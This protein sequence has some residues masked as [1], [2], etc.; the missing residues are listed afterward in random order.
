MQATLHR[1]HPVFDIEAEIVRA[2]NC[3]SPVDLKSWQDR[4]DRAVGKTT[5]GKSRLR[6]IWG[7]DMNLA[8]MFSCGQRRS[9][10][11]F[12]RYEEDGAIHDI[13][14]PRFYVEE[15]H[16]NFELQQKGLWDKARFYYDEESREFID[17]LG[18]IP[19]E[20]FYSCVF[21]IAHHDTLCCDGKGV[22]NNEPCLGAYRGP[23]DTDMQRIRR[24]KWRRDHASNDERLPSESRI[25]KRSQDATEKRDEHWRAGIRAAIEDY[26]KTRSFA[27]T[28]LDPGLQ[29]WGRYHFLAAHNRSGLKRE[30]NNAN[31]DSNGSAPAQDGA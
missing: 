8:S 25:R 20:G 22:V 11:P 24:M 19:E 1:S 14:V 31:S 7:Q 27:W 17:V 5:D 3:P 21:L 18:P 10:Y 2:K 23:V 16:G 26:S 15:L 13:G 29:A 12:W 28:S 9:K 30:N 6:I 4:I